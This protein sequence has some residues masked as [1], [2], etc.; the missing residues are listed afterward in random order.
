M[1]ASFDLAQHIVSS[2]IFRTIAPQNT[3][4]SGE[5]GINDRFARQPAGVG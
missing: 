2:T 4:P 1:P 3:V 5:C